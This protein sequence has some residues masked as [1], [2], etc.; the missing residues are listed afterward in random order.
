MI[1]TSASLPLLLHAFVGIALTIALIFF[2]WQFLLPFFR[3]R[4]QLLAAHRAIETLKAGGESL[5]A[6]R[7]GEIM[8]DA[9]LRHCWS[10]YRDTLHAQKTVNA[11]GVAQAGRWRATAIASTFFTEQALVNAPLRTEFYKHLPGILTGIGIIGTFGGLI[12]GLNDFKISDDPLVVRSSLESL[13]SSV[14]GAFKLSG[15]AIF[16]AMAITTAEKVI[17]NKLYT[18]V[19][20]LCGLIDSLFES[21]AGEEYLQRLVDASE[22]SATQAMQ[23]KESLVTD[24]KQVL[25]ELTQ[26]QINAIRTTS[27]ELGTSI[28]HS[29]TE[30]LAEPL[31]RIS[32]AVQTV[33]NSQGEAV[34]RILTD[35]LSGF[36]SQ[37]ENMFG[38]QLRGMNDMLLKTANTIES[39]SQGFN[40]LAVQIQQAGTGAADAMARRVEE[41]LGQI[42]SRQ[43]EANAQMQS[44]VD[45]LKDSVARGQAESADLTQN[46]LRQVSD[47][48]ASFVKTLQDQSQ[49][50][51]AEGAAQQ[52]ET[53]ARMQVFVDE[54]KDGLARG[55]AESANLTRDM[56]QQMSEGTSSFVRDL[57]EQRNAS[58]AEAA[59]VQARASER[60]HA[61][62]EE[63]R[64]SMSKGQSEASEAASRLID[65][66]N[67]KASGMIDAL[68][69]Q[70]AAAH[71]E[72]DQRQAQLA[73]QIAEL[74]DRQTGQINSVT[75]AVK[76][77]SL[78]M[79]QAV[80]TLNAATHGHI[81]RMGQGAAR[82][83][84]ASTHF[85]DNLLDLKTA[86]DGIAGTAER[87][88]QAAATL[89][90]SLSAVQQTLGDQRAVRDALAGMV[91]EL[92]AVLQTVSAEATLKRDLVQSMEQAGTSLREA[93]EATRGHLDD[94][95]EDLAHVHQ[96]FADQVRKTLRESNSAFHTELAQATGLLKGAIVDLGDVFDRLP[97][98]A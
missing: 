50:G 40:T 44:F 65:Q 71:D 38:S 34:S 72:H 4:A 88:K 19:D 73:A 76:Q 68:Q 77:G 61:W 54:L 5:D 7:I 83:H 90:G 11:S 53:N 85:A 42:Q 95:I 28:T 33:G 31:A 1:F 78:A 80:D 86:T 93:Q 92:R 81:E 16:F 89:D 3:V 57:Q 75:E 91:T 49:K 97:T 26:Q 94:L 60:I 20:A 82:L 8:Q 51:L 41:S 96:E 24:L 47:S 55:Q 87:F 43:T 6:D 29:L 56:L 10:E 66:L 45:S 59:E 39:A 70:T 15:L 23:M 46:M 2:V 14:G 62:M 67:G 18:H 35:V 69:A 17:V 48:T 84:D 32:N 63:T 98:A 9:A 13:V 12:L 36:T 22:T 21:G 79:T 64:V 27:S 58:R 25:S 52:A 30:G 37:M 74:L